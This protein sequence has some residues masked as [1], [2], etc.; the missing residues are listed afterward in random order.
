MT[1]LAAREQYTPEFKDFG[2]ISRL[3]TITALVTEKI[4][5][6]NAQILV[7]DD[8]ALPVLAGSRNRFVTPEKDNFGF[9]RFVYENA[10]MFR[11]LGPGRHFGEW[12]G[13]GIGR[14]Y[15]QTEKFLSLFNVGRYGDGL[16]E[17]LPANVRLVPVLWTGPVDTSAIQAVI[18][19]LYATGSVAVP[20][21][22]KPEGVIVQ[23]PSAGVRWKVTD[24]GDAH[25]GTE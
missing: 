10:E 11:R 20:G 25:K 13:A 7:P 15:G 17:G 5:G 9:A 3:R 14:R 2:K 23:I 12:W 18:D 22:M 16:P 1:E 24:N 19:N 21:W 6:T 8:P 4:D